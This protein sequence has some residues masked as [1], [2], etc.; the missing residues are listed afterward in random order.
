MGERQRALPFS[1]SYFALGPPM[2]FGLVQAQMIFA[3]PILFTESL[4]GTATR[5]KCIP[6][7]VPPISIPA[8]AL[9]YSTATGSEK[10]SKVTVAN[11]PPAFG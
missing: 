7:S 9:M 1:Y 11:E 2:Y 5:R 8:F 3:S 4:T 10:L 6:I